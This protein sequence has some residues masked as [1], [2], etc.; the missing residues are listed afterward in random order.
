MVITRQGVYFTL[1]DED[2]VRDF[3]PL[4]EIE[5][6]AAKHDGDDDNSAG[7]AISAP[8][9]QDIRTKS[10]KRVKTVSAY[11]FF[12]G[13]QI[14]TS[15]DG[16]NSGRTYHV[17]ADSKDNCKNAVTMLAQYSQRAKVAAQ[18][19]TEFEKSQQFLLKIHNSIWYQTI[20]TTLI[21][22][23]NIRFNQS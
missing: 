8:D 10:L 19:R 6:I 7:Q 22:A 18:K 11:R 13:F 9:E 2:D 12:F 4:S 17:Q 20:A 3:I 14:E 5:R 1:V 16:Y 15:K 23:V 21:L